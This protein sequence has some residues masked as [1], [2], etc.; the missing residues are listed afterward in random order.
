MTANICFKVGR[1]LEDPDYKRSML[2]ILDSISHEIDEV[3]A[4]FILSA[5]VG[6]EKKGICIHQFR[7]ILETVCLLADDYP[8]EIKQEI[9]ATYKQVE[10]VNELHATE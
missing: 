6:L 10:V 4:V 5:R 3:N 8:D 2:C 9:I 1:Y 7:D